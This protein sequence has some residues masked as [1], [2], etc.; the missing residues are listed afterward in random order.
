VAGVAGYVAPARYP[1]TVLHRQ[2]P[3][4]GPGV[5][6]EG[7]PTAGK[8]LCG[9]FMAAGELWTPVDGRDGDQLCTGCMLPGNAPAPAGD[10]DG[11]LF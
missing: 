2:D 10:T 4:A 3:A 9:L 11:A 5:D 1:L 7:E 6:G 8:T